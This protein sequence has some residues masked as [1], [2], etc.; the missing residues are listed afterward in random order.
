MSLSLDLLKR[1]LV[2]GTL[3]GVVLIA[4]VWWFA[5][6]TPEANKLASA[7][8]QVQSDQSQIS[9]LNT[10]IA[11]LKVED[12]QLPHLVHY[13]AFFSLAI[14]PLPESGDLTTE[15]YDL[16]LSTKTVMNTLTDVATINTGKGYS[17]IPV[18]IS[19]SGNHNSVL[20]FL[21]G[22]YALPRLVT[23]QSIN[24]SPP[25]GQNLNQPST[26]SG[27][28]ANISATAYT[29]YVPPTPTAPAA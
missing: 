9:S 16:S 1:P 28:T 10:Q 21:K 7:N 22:I 4:L 3:I 23:I 29:T 13:L 20:A 6:M 11:A 2:Y 8:S 12:Q 18:Q 5:W 24:L 27:F 15:L 25:G 17:T 14:P 26:A 19:L